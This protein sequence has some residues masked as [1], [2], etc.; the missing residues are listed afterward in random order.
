MTRSTG[1]KKLSTKF[2]PSSICGSRACKAQQTQP[3]SQDIDPDGALSRR[4]EECLRPLNVPERM[5]AGL[6]DTAH[7]LAR[8][9]RCETRALVRRKRAIREFDAA[10]FAGSRFVSSPGYGR[11]IFRLQRGEKCL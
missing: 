7:A 6:T 2:W 4:C 10:P 8:L 9:R 5:A 3:F 11:A 1:Q